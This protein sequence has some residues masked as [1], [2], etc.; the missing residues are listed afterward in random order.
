[1]LAKIRN[2]IQP[3]WRR[4]TQHTARRLSWFA[5]ILL[6]ALDGYILTLLFDGAL[7][8]GLMIDHADHRVSQTCASASEQL[9]NEELD[10]QADT[11][12]SFADTFSENRDKVS[13]DFTN[14][15]GEIAP[16]CVA[17]RDKWIT[18]LSAAL[19]QLLPLAKERSD[20]FEERR[21]TERSIAQL[22]SSYSDALL[23]KIAGQS[24]DD[25]I[26]PA[27]ANQIKGKLKTLNNTLDE[28]RQKQQATT[29]AMVRQPAVA[30]Y[31][32]YLQTAPLKAEFAKE[33]ELFARRQFWYPVKVIA[34]QAAFLI[35]LLLLAIFWNRRA[36][37]KQQDT[38]ILVSS[39]M[40]LVCALPIL[41]RLLDMLLNLLPHQLLFFLLERLTE[42]RLIFI[43]NYALIFACLA[44]GLLLIYIAQR[45]LFSAARLRLIRL[46]KAQCQACGEKLRTRDQGWCEVCGA[47]QAAP[48]RQ[49]G[50]PRRLL[51][52]HCSHC[53]T[54]A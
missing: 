43:W 11:I 25:S 7:N 34:A 54:S 37:R 5:L 6:F 35:P 10:D 46:R 20:Q 32:Q 50:Q 23:E 24:R 42:W 33:N 52:F 49:C 47:N 38:S 21:Q 36:I 29:Y 13:H 17:I 39:H 26:L 45:T 8:A 18:A 1:M 53:G 3:K 44:G 41:L 4:L 48:C 31:L 27:E 2:L 16:L 22:K 40:I 30:T 12:A 9:L 15:H 14:D 51:A 28:L 19:P